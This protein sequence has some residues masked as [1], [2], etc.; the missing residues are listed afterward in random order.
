MGS[1]GWYDGSRYGNLT[2]TPDGGSVMFVRENR[3]WRMPVSG[4]PPVDMGITERAR[5]K[6]PA[7][8]PTGRR[9][10]YSTVD[11]DTNEVWVLENFLPGPSIGR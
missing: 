1:V 6:A 9:L 11:S 4:G 8:D 3:L 5:I 10:A 2:W 7:I